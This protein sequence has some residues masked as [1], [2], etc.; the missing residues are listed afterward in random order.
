MGEGEAEEEDSREN[1]RDPIRR[2]KVSKQ[3]GAD[4][5]HNPAYDYIGSCY[6]EDIPPGQ[7]SEN[8]LHLALNPEIAVTSGQN[9]NM[10]KGSRKPCRS[11]GK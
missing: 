8:I 1:V 11:Y 7:F 2:A 6:P 4:L 3:N 5:Q 10:A 9:T